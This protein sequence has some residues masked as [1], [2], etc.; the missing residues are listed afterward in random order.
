MNILKVLILGLF[1][2]ACGSDESGVTVGPEKS[3]ENDVVELEPD[4]SAP[5]RFADD[6]M[7]VSFRFSEDFDTNFTSF[8]DEATESYPFYQML[9]ILNASPNYS[10]PPGVTEIGFLGGEE[11]RI[12]NDN[13]DATHDDGVNGVYKDSTAEQFEFAG[14]VVR[15]RVS[16]RHHNIGQED[17][18]REIL[19]VDIYFNTRDYI[20]SADAG[21]AVVHDMLTIYMRGMRRVLKGDESNRGFFKRDTVDRDLNTSDADVIK[22]NYLAFSPDRGGE[23]E[24]VVYWE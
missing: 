21:D 12:V 19:E 7:P 18:W 5:L 24:D 23:T 15:M 1:L 20:F 3:P 16:T 4:P 22:E 8:Y 13:T 6:S 11:S 14:Q 17:E 10:F 2:A 9:E